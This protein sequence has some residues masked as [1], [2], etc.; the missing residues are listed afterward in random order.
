MFPVE[1]PGIESACLPGDL[2]SERQFRSVS[3]RFS[4]A[5]YLRF[6]SRVL[7]ASKARGILRNLGCVALF[8]RETHACLDSHGVRP[9][10]AATSSA[11]A[12]P[13]VGNG[14]SGQITDDAGGGGA[15]AVGSPMCWGQ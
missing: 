1:L 5:H 9:L 2:P 14:D 4:P 15:C 8:P 3:F 10:S 6:R 11:Y 12:A 13:G 7:T